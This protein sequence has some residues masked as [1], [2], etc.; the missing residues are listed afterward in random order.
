MRQ[1]LF[2]LCLGLLALACAPR[3]APRLD[4]R[5]AATPA[6]SAATAL[7]TQSTPPRVTLVESA[8]VETTLGSPELP[9]TMDV[10]PEMIAAAKNT[11]ELSHFYASTRPGERLEAVIEAL[12]QAAARGVGIRMLF[13][14]RLSDTYADTFARLDAAFELRH[15]D[16]ALELGGILHAKY[17]IIDDQQAF[18]GSA[19]FDWRSLTHL[20]EIGL[21]IEVP[22]LATALRGLFEMDWALALPGA[23]P[24]P[25]TPG[26]SWPTL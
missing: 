12:E 6:A 7:V 17:L 5:A 23:T 26:A 11:I 19:N 24:K 4:D 1:V 9:D 16:A 15:W 2:S 8:P 3:P 20:H 10:W 14:S 21:R 22:T 13:D 18:V 25:A